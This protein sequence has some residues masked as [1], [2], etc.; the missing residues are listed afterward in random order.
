M[1]LCPTEGDK[2]YKSGHFKDCGENFGTFDMVGNVWEWVEDKNVLA[3]LIFGGSFQYGEKADCN[4]S[5]VSSIIAE[6]EFTGFR[7]CK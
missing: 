2:I 6:S 4:F 3:P 5:S 1:D 7:C